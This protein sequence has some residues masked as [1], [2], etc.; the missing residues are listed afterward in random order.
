MMVTFPDFYI[1]SRV[2]DIKFNVKK[3]TKV[4]SSL[5]SNIVNIYYYAKE[6]LHKLFLSPCCRS[7]AVQFL[8][9]ESEKTIHESAS[10]CGDIFPDASNRDSGPFYS[11]SISILN[12]SLYAPMDLDTTKNTLFPPLKVHLV[13]FL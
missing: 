13:S 8:L 7:I 2:Y 11:V 1:L 6:K 10:T 9:G 5:N 3:A 4:Q 12:Y